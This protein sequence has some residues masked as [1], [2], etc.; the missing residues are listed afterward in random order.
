M[1]VSLN[2]QERDLRSSRYITLILAAIL[3]VT[4]AAFMLALV[5]L[6]RLQSEVDAV[7]SDLE[8]PQMAEGHVDTT[9]ILQARHQAMQ[10]KKL[11]QHDGKPASRMLRML[12]D[13]LP[14]DVRLARLDYDGRQGMAAFT[15]ES[16]DMASLG[17]YVRRLERMPGVARVVVLQ[18]ESARAESRYSTYEVLLTAVE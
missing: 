4:F 17:E 2:F 7:R 13:A 18:Q 11:V 16:A 1:T 6:T 5:E 3:T 10:L 15:A 8:S 14:S 12:G 9:D